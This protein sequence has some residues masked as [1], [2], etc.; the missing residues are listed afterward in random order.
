[1]S[2]PRASARRLGELVGGCVSR[3]LARQGFAASELILHWEDIV[4]P[5]IAVN[6]APLRIR[7]PRGWAQEGEPAILVLRVEGPVAIE[8]QHLSEIILQRINSFFGWRAIGKLALQ[9]GPIA[10]RQPPPVAAPPSEQAT[11]D[12]A[13]RLTEIT[14]TDLRQALARLGA[15]IKRA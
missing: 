12:V 5:Q 7:W 13:A 11:A 4:G 3:S 15:S 2:K 8:I 9:Q 14:D 10:R 6:A 1:V